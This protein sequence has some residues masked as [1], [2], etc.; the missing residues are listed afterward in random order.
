VKEYI[1]VLGKEEGL[2]CSVVGFLFCSD[3]TI[4]DFNNK[5]LSHNY[6]TDILTFYDTDDDGKLE[7]DIIISPDTVKHN[8]KRFKKDFSEELFRVVLHGLLHLCGY[9]DKDVKNQ[10]VMR[11]MED[12]YL[13]KVGY[14]QLNT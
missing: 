2:N 6:E 12:H 8:S 4:K 14:L 11:K 7:S 9:D 1:T 5:Y 13:Q 3:D 10:K